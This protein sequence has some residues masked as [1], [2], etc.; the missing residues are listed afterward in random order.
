MKKTITILFLVTIITISS[1]AAC[2]YNFFE[3]YFLGKRCTDVYISD[4]MINLYT[5]N[6]NI[7]V[8]NMNKEK[9]TIKK[10]EIKGEKTECSINEKDIETLYINN[11]INAEGKNYISIPC[12]TADKEKKYEYKIVYSDDKSTEQTVN[13][14][15]ELNAESITWPTKEMCEKAVTDELCDS[16]Q[17]IYPQKGNFKG[18]A[19][20]CKQNFELCKNDCVVRQ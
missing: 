19:C 18:F 3:K 1:V 16:M 11:E 7:E 12:S 15:T 14:K 17:E 4:S 13:K 10:I 2:E 6:V 9:I 20:E 5:G 8:S